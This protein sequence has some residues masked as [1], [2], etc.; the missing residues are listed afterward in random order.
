MPGA[1]ARHVIDQRRAEGGHQQIDGAVRPA[2]LE[3]THNGMAAD[4]V[5]D[6]H[7]GHDQ[8]RPRIGG[9]LHLD[10]IE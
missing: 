10:P 4:E 6:P 8:D 7:I 2:L 9:I 3:D 1:D 5:A